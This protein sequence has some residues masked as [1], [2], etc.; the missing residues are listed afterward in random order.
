MRQKNQ[1]NKDKEEKILVW[2]FLLM[3]LFVLYM[4]TEASGVA[5]WIR[6]LMKH[7]FIK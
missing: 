2:I 4:L 7:V 3:V 6:E 1:P 5:D